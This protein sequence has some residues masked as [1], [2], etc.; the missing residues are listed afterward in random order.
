M[1]NCRESYGRDTRLRGAP[2]PAEADSTRVFRPQRLAI[3]GA[4]SSLIA[5]VV[6][7]SAPTN[8]PLEGQVSE[9]EPDR[10]EP[11]RATNNS[12]EVHSKGLCVS[13]WAFFSAVVDRLTDLMG[14]RTLQRLRWLRM[15]AIAREG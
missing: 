7:A 12:R 11:P 2:D 13:H 14:L 9:S 4:V 5:S 3:L 1:T 15:V 10:A 8:Q 6:V